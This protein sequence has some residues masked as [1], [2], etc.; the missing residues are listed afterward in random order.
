[1]ISATTADGCKILSHVYF[2]YMLW[3]LAQRDFSRR[4]GIS[5][6]IFR[7]PLP[8]A[9]RRSFPP[10]S[11]ALQSFPHLVRTLGP[12][13]CMEPTLGSTTAQ[14]SSGTCP[15]PILPQNSRKRCP[16]ITLV[17]LTCNNVKIEHGY[18]PL[19]PV[20]TYY[21]PPPKTQRQTLSVADTV[22][23]CVFAYIFVQRS[24]IRRNM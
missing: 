23:R 10:G 5:V 13:G 11:A 7:L 4:W 20:I 19:S 17:R 6:K 16:S 9:A 14:Q 2:I 22:C 21:W 12:A 15:A 8:L 1:M 3:I 18:S 24:I